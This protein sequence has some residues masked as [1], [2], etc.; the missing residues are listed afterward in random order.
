MLDKLTGRVM[1]EE[2][3]FK[4]SIAKKGKTWEEIYGINGAMQRR[5]QKGKK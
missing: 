3:K 2:Q 4:M 1:S 5:I